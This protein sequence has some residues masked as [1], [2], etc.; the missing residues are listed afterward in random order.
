[1]IRKTK[2][3]KYI[4]FVI[5]L[6]YCFAASA[7]TA[8]ATGNPPV[9][10]M[11]DVI[12]Q[13]VPE[14]D[15]KGEEENRTGGGYAVTDQIEGVGYS[16]TIYDASSGLP[17]SDANVVLGSSD[18]CIW[19]GGYS[20]IICYDG[21]TFERMDTS[22]GLTSGRGLFEDSLGRIWVGTNDNGVV[23]LDGDERTHLTYRDG[24]PSS[25]IRVFAEDRDGNIYIGTTAGV[26]YVDNN[27]K[28]NIIDDDRFNTDRILKLDS[29]RSGRIYGM[30]K[31][32]DVFMIESGKVTQY[33]R[34]V[35]L[36]TKTITTILADPENEGM[37]YLGTE[38]SDIYYGRFGDTAE[39]LK[40]IDVSPVENTHWMSYDCGR[41]WIS[42]TTVMGYLDDNRRFHKVDN[43]PMNS[44][45]EMHT[46]DYQGN[47]WAASST[48]GV[49]KI[50]TSNFCDLTLQN[51]LAP[52]VVNATCLHNGGI[53]IGTDSGLQIIGVNGKPV[54]NELTS[55]LEGARIR[56]IME[57]SDKNLWICTFSNEHGLVRYTPDGDIKSFTT[58]LGLPSNEVRCAIESKNHKQILIGT[59]GGLAVIS[60]GRVVK[61]VGAKEGIKN[62]VFLTLAE[63]DD[64]KIYAGTD[65]DGIY[66][67]DGSD[68]SVIGRD[69]GL[70]SDV[71]MRIRKDEDQG[72]FWIV[73]SNSIEYMRDGMITNVRSFPYNNNYDVCYDDKDN[74][75]VLSSF[76]LYCVSR[77]E[78][79]SDTVSDYRL[80]TTANGLP[81][82]PTSNSYSALDSSGNLYISSRTGVS[83]ININDFFEEASMIKMKLGSI[84]FNDEPV[85]PDIA[86][87]YTIP[88]G[89]GRLQITPAVLDYSLTNPTVR[90]FLDGS[91]DKGITV[92]RNRLSTLEYTGLSYG[93]YILHIQILDNAAEKVIQ[94]ETYRVVKKPM[95]FELLIVRILIAA[96]VVLLAGVIVW[97]ALR[98]TIIRRQYEEIRLAKEEAEQANTAKSRF[99][100]N[101]S[102]EIRTPINTI[103]GMDEMI[104]RED[105]TDVPQGYFMSIINYALDIRGA[106]ESLLSLINDL[107]DIS[108][109]ESGKM[110]LV[111]Q[112]YDVADLM[113]SIVSMIHVRADEKDL[114]FNISIDEMLPSK[115]YGD[116]GKIKQ[117][118]LNLLTNAVK[119]TDMG[120]FT[121]SVTMEERE[122]E[123]CDLRISVKDTGIGIKSEDLDK[124]FSAY[125]RLD[126]ERNSAIQGTGLGLDISKRF[127]ELM[128]GRLWCESVYGDGSEFILTVSQKITDAAPMGKFE[129]REETETQGPYVPRFVAPDADVLVVDDNPMNLGV[130]KG[131]LKAT[132]VFVTTA[133]SGEECLEKLKYGTFNVV[134]LDHMMPGMDG[135]ETVARIRETMPELPVYALT[136]NSTAGEE[137]YISKGFNGYLS[138]P[139]D[140]RTLELAI[141][142]HI[143]EE[144]MMKAEASDIVSEPEELPEDLAWLKQVE[145][146]VA[147][148]GI[149]NSGGVSGFSNAVRMFV[150]TIEENAKVIEDALKQENIRLYT[151]KVHSLKTSARIIGAGSLSALAEKLEEAGNKNNVSFIRENAARLLEDY[152]SFRDR[153]GRIIKKEDEAEKELIPEDEM[154]DAY[155]A[156]KELIPQM[157]YDSV[158]MILEQL[159]E[160]RLSAEDEKRVERLSVLLKTFK[161]EEM[162]EI[163]KDV[164]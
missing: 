95:F 163:I 115:L 72:L 143:P 138:K 81:S 126:E 60:G 19:I 5:V 70:T 116:S 159:G 101:M 84:V 122:D 30:S 129:E 136:A 2:T 125:E 107:L 59:N 43:I 26:C 128:G 98:G 131:L 102:H 27:M 10:G 86:G 99:L 23:V 80:Y 58:T 6:A 25:S 100:A 123:R 130:I 96:L 111:E 151:V 44:A 21:S 83:R 155:D 64:G 4:S 67:I 118:I 41:V 157:D 29:D 3:L 74:L 148:D 11:D 139:I 133:S 53:Y 9:S 73:T 12:M 152:R 132:K 31:S 108:K 57:D 34:S 46:S 161:W 137:F 40:K 103:M 134:L 120:G 147:E 55:Y 93:N 87:I 24:L 68:I 160:Y 52:D 17:T 91:S 140:S 144:I 20:G 112:E 164:G 37:I 78:M 69:D 162:E 127:A 32:G 114:F 54:R 110:H 88:A 48:Q 106:S 89:P 124:L 42:S 85:L 71:V 145:G 92:E 135:V 82:V 18:G 7:L 117:I 158:E 51:K 142:K 76:G 22:D 104:L 62:T 153:L 39:R 14:T 28:V 146:I 75:W 50:V 35:D 63:A 150:Q 33:Y 49:M 16:S 141:M 56:H 90:V 47:I 105:A 109:I 65:G 154:K 15:P 1:M 119:Y 8:A 156:L 149:R 13:S 97:R 45:I 38:S 121:L 66:V 113:R 94:E 77:I 79:I 36:K 61:T